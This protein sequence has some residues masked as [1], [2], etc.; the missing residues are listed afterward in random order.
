[1]ILFKVDGVRAGLARW[2][3]IPAPPPS[4]ES[5]N[6]SESSSESKSESESDDFVDLRRRTVLPRPSKSSARGPSPSSDP[7]DR[8]LS[9]GDETPPR[10]AMED[11]HTTP[12]YC[13]HGTDSSTQCG[14]GN[15]TLSRFLRVLINWQSFLTIHATD[16]KGAIATSMI[17]IITVWDPVQHGMLG[18]IPITLIRSTTRYC[19]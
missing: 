2:T 17:R 12:L 7:N 11:G 4:S 14:K 16:A 15:V 10:P 18:H 8:K 13:Y 3:N 1:M 9:R 6:L 5:A 19:T